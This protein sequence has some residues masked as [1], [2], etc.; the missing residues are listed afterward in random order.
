MEIYIFHCTFAVSST[1][2]M[3]III[4]FISEESQRRASAFHHCIEHYI[5]VLLVFV[6]IY[7]LYYI[8]LTFI[9]FPFVELCIVLMVS[10]DVFFSLKVA[11][12]YNYCSACYD[13]PL[14][15]V[16][17]RNIH[18]LPSTSVCVCWDTGPTL[19]HRLACGSCCTS[20]RMCLYT[21]YSTRHLMIRLSLRD[22]ML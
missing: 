11:K 19:D 8:Q 9:K 14:M 6:Y 3:N 18:R 1:L 15:G 20:V 5:F 13:C 17:L 16:P 10:F 7:I 12:P 2:Y 4:R 22:L 21:S